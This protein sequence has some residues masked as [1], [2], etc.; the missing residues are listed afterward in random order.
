MYYILSREFNKWCSIAHW[1][2]MQKQIKWFDLIYFLKMFLLTLKMKKG[3]LPLWKLCMRTDVLRK[4][5]WSILAREQRDSDL[6]DFHM[7]LLHINHRWQQW[8]L[9]SVGCH[10]VSYQP[11]DCSLHSHSSRRGQLGVK[12]SFLYSQS[13][14]FPIMAQSQRDRKQKK[15]L[16]PRG[17][18]YG[19]NNWWRLKLKN[20]CGWMHV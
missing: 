9:C 7:W 3:L 18:S 8:L 2:S 5:I 1:C 10:F 12:G 16:L 20:N 15:T 17:S 6:N 14:P 11:G 13:L 4:N 19:K